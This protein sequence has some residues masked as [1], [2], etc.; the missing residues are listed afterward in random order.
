VPLSPGT[1]VPLAGTS[2]AA[3]PEWAGTVLADVARPF[4]VDLSAFGGGIIR[5]TVQDRVVRETV[6]S[7]L[8]LLS[9][10]Q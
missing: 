5:G 3:R 2:A 1:F 7:T 4:F 6:S 8:D 10:L 9:R